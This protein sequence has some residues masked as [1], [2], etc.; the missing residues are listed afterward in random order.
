MTLT[1]H[2][3]LGKS[4]AK[5]VFRMSYNYSA[6]YGYTDILLEANRL[7]YTYYPGYDRFGNPP[8]PTPRQMAHYSKLDLKTVRAVLSDKELL[9]LMGLV[10]RSGFMR[11]KGGYGASKYERYYGYTLSARLNGHKQTVVYRSGEKEITPLPEAYRQVQGKL[12]DLIKA[13]FP[14][15][16]TLPRR[17]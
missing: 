7:S 13:K 4:E 10:K 8:D 2:P 9:D 12:V 14:A 3:T 1:S 16:H 11:L 6:E 15:V 17:L 5:Q